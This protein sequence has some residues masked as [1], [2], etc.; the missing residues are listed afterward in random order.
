MTFDASISHTYIHTHATCFRGIRMPR[1][2][3]TRLVKWYRL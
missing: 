1:F 3:K 2:D